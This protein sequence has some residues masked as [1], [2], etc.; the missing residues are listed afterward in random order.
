MPVTDALCRVAQQAV[1]LALT[2]ILLPAIKD[3]MTHLYLQN[4]PL[5]LQSNPTLVISATVISD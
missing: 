4:C 5:W 3:F 1:S 2:V